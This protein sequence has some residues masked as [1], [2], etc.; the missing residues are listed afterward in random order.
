[1]ILL[2]ATIVGGALAQSRSHMITTQAELMAIPEG[3]TDT[4]ILQAN[5]DINLDYSGGGGKRVAG[6][7]SRIS[8]EFLMEMAFPSHS[9]RTRLTIISLPRTTLP[10]STTSTERLDMCA[11][12]IAMGFLAMG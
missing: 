5:I 9:R 11:S 12:I 8:V 6:H 7:P 1:M 4:Y 3:S 2:L 10:S